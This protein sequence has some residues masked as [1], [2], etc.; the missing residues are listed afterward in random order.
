M[1]EKERQWLTRKIRMMMLFFMVAVAISGITAFDVE[2]GL[3]WLVLYEDYYPDAIAEFLLK[4]YD[5]VSTT[6]RLYPMLGYG[7][8]W[9]AFAHL[10]IALLFIGP[11][12][13]PVKNQWVVTWAMITC[14]AV[15]PLAFIA[16]SI[17]G[18]P[19]YWQLIDCSFGIIGLI[20]L[21]ITN[22]WIN[23]LKLLQ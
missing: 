17:R 9:L 23:R 20:P 6:N 3:Q 21:Y 15:F 19:F 10:V 1:Q 4:A 2:P 7:Y 13:E 16:G 11:Y 14:I 18:I 12:R 22:R 8:D 5:A